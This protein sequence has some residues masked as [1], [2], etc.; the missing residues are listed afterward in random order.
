MSDVSR[1]TY[2]EE[3][4]RDFRVVFFLA[5]P[6]FFVGALAGR[7]LPRGAAYAGR[8]GSVFAEA[9]AAAYRTLPYAF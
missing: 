4:D 6:L 5:Y 2:R 8:R 3:R 7:L 9:S 1:T